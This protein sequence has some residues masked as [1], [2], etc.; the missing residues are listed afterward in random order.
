MTR[1]EVLAQVVFAEEG[2]CRGGFGE[3]FGCVVRGEVGL[4]WGRVVAEG[5]AG[6][7]DVTVLVVVGVVYWSRGETGP[8]FEGQVD[9]G[10]VSGPVVAGFEGFWAEG[11][12]VGAGWGWVVVVVVLVRLGLRFSPPGAASSSIL[13]T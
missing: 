9:G 5:A 11:A 8:F 3:T 1:P 12:L 7:G 10:L 13:S 4:G 6:V 2:A